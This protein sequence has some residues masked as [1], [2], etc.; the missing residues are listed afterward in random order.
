MQ[1]PWKEYT[2]DGQRY[3]IRADYGF[4][5][6]GEQEPYFSVTGE[7]QRAERGRW[8]KDSGGMQHEQIARHFP[9]LK[10]LLKWHLTFVESGPM[11][12]VANGLYW[13]EEG[14]LD[15]FKS[16]VVFGAVPGDKLPSNDASQT[17]VRNWLLDRFPKLMTAFKRDM[18]NMD[19]KGAA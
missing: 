8:R 12:Y 7:I 19:K 3:R 4:V 18:I 10:P 11:H 13:W 1:T 14:N 15:H 2:E 6:L 16:T 5:K 17:E 9:K